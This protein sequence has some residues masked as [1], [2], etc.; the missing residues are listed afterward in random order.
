M[1][2]LRLVYDSYYL[3][4]IVSGVILMLDF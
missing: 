1:L 2:F 3:G 4:M